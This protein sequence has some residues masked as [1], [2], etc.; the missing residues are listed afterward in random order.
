MDNTN[1][2]WHLDKRST[3]E[4]IKNDVDKMIEKLEVESRGAL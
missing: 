2:A 3:P 4:W 1:P